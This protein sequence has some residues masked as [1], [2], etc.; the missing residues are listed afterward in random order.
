MPIL[1]EPQFHSGHQ[2]LHIPASQVPPPQVIVHATTTTSFSS[3]EHAPP[4]YPV[5]SARQSAHSPPRGF[6]GNPPVYIPSPSPTHALTEALTK[7]SQLYCLPQ[8]KPDTFKGD[9]RDK[10]KFFLWENAFESLV[11][12]APITAHQ[13]LHLLYQHLDG[14]AKKVVE[15]QYMVQDP[16]RAYQHARKILKERFGHTAIISTIFERKL[17]TWPKVG[18]NDATGMEEFSDFLSQVQIASEHIQSLKVL[19]LSSKIQT[20]VE[21]LP[22]WFKTKWSDKVLKLQ[23]KEGK[24]AFPSFKDFVNEVSYHAERMNVPQIVQPTGASGK[25][26]PEHSKPFTRPLRHRTPVVAL[27]SKLPPTSNEE[28]STLS[29]ETSQVAQT[30]IAQAQQPSLATTL[31]AYC[32]YHKRK[33][34]AMNECDQFQRSSFQERKDF[35]MKNRICFNCVSTNKHIAKSCNRDKPEARH[36]T[37]LPKQTQGKRVKSGQLCLLPS[38][39]TAIQHV[40]VLE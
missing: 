40:R 14:Q 29:D 31:D 2:D 18:P 37:T 9:E 15:L 5:P 19:N 39:W 33:S 26:V 27:A 30:L 23:R 25:T 35:L 21:K 17:S 20:L 36:H 16:E 22:G 24:N 28:R 10:T 4:V 34:H 6:H 11:G 13:K 7:V 1:T 32:L 8:A 3:G 38:L 12:S